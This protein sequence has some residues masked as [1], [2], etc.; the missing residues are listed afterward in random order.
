[1][2]DAAR[3]SPAG[4]AVVGYRQPP[5][6][7]RFQKGKSGNPRGRP[8][9]KKTQAERKVDPVL[10][11]HLG[12]LVLAEAIRPIQ[13]RE[14]DEIIELPLI[15]AVIRSLGVA[16]LKGSHRAQIAI[17]SMVKAVQDKILDDRGVLFK[18]AIAYKDSREEVFEACDRRGEPRP[19]PV[20]HPHEVLLDSRTLQVRFNGPETPDDKK[21]WDDFLAQRK[22]ALAEADELRRRLRR[23]SRYSSLLQDDLERCE[24]L[25]DMIGSVIPDEET[26]RRPGFEIHEWRERQDAM[27][28]LRESARQGRAND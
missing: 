26:R 3:K 18:A 14:N 19:E 5:V 22:A 21:V 11:H 1:M 7:H 15:Q 24:R 17:T 2:S 25:A 8:P 10:S 27:R 28:K 16:A 20:P 4:T 9:K 6:E 12:D 13:I 23:P